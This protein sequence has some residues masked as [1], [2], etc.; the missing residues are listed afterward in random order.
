MLIP[1]SPYKQLTSLSAIYL[2]KKVVFELGGTFRLLEELKLLGVDRGSGVLLVLD[3]AVK[4]LDQVV[5]GVK[6]LEEAGYRVDAYTD[7]EYEPTIECAKR[8]AEYAWRGDYRAVVG[9]G[10]GS[11]IDLAKV[12]AVGRDN[13]GKDIELFIGLDKVPRRLTPLIALPTTAGTAAE[14]SRFSIFTKGYSKTGIHGVHVMPDVAV[15]DPALTYSLPP[16]VTAGTGLD[17]LSHAVEGLLSYDST[18]FS[19][20][21]AYLSIELIFKYLRRAYFKGSDVEARYFMSLAATTAGIPLNVA[22]VILG[23]SIS[24]VVGPTYKLHHGAACGMALPYIMDFYFPVAQEKL[25]VI[26]RAAGVDT[27]LLDVQG[28]AEEA[29]RATWD[30][31]MDLDIPLSLRE[32]GVSRAE[33][34]ALAERTVKEWP[35]P[36]SPIDLTKERVLKVYQAM[37]EGSLV[38]V[39]VGQS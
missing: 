29:V 38:R 8:L 34:E 33:L 2:P 1:Y 7:I 10:G 6:L 13:P 16:R 23:H 35:R 25:A 5:K 28:A 9:I 32:V 24:Q 31:V 11:T 19:D 12:A 18:L 22:R 4:H 20:V 37:Y 15:V 39:K 30:L 3:P 14:V 27:A 26:A 17:A 36:N 21:A